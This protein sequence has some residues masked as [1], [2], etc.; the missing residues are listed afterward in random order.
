[1]NERGYPFKISH[2]D[3]HTRTVLHNLILDFM[4]CIFFVE[5][6]GKKHIIY[7]TKD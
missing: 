5:E 7:S 3:C 1:M 2:E 4:I 6:G